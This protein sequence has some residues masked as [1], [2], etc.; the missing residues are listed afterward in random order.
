MNSNLST[1]MKIRLLHNL[2]FK[3]VPSWEYRKVKL[4][5]YLL[6]S[7]VFAIWRDDGILKTNKK[8]D[9]NTTLS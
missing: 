4:S 7:P 1:V 8:T 6:V 9:G 2:V 3:Y 5:K